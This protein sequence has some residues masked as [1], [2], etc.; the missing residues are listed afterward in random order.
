MYVYIK[1]CMCRCLSIDIHDALITNF[2]LCYQF[3]YNLI[4]IKYK[5]ANTDF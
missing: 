2:S 3:S 4:K 5:C 1:T